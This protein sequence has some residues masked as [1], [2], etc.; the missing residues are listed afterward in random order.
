MNPED[1]KKIDNILRILD[2]DIHSLKKGK[3]KTILISGGSCSGKS[4]IAQKI[5][6]KYPDFKAINTGDIFREEARFLGI[7]LSEFMKSGDDADENLIR[8]DKNVDKKII[9][10]LIE[11]DDN[12]IL[13]SRFGAV[14][15]VVLDSIDRQNISLFLSVSEKEKIARFT[16]REFKKN[17]NNITLEEKTILSADI[18]RDQ[19]DISRYTRI[20]NIDPLDFSRYSHNLDT[21]LINEEGLYAA[22]I[23]LLDNFIK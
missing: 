17:P 20:Y 12:I 16:K 11:S 14:W 19:N 15:G 21:T 9:K 23:Q 8:L 13:T 4:F 5:A 2:I 22:V 18:K 1:K 6:E 7:P 3:G 10:L